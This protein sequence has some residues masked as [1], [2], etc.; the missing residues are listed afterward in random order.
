M[1]AWLSLPRVSVHPAAASGRAGARPSPRSRSV[2]GHRQANTWLPP[3][4][5]RSAAPTW[6]ACTTV[7]RGP[8]TSSS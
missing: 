5:S 4:T 2:V 1:T 8:S 3:S 7:V 6:V